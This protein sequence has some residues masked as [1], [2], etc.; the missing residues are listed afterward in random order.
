MV[1][2]S[3][4]D[5]SSL[6]KIFYAKNDF[7]KPTKLCVLYEG[8]ARVIKINYALFYEYIGDMF[9]KWNQATVHT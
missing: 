8:L 6:V 3:S 9:S 5:G 7:K 4:R 1:I 2:F